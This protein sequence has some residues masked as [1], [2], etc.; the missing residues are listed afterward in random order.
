MPDFQQTIN[1]NQPLGY[2]G[3]LAFSG[4][5]RA[6][7]YNL[8]STPQVNAIGNA[9]TVVNGA[10]P[11]PAA[12]SAN[13]GT[14]KVGGTGVFA[15]ILVNPKEYASFGGVAGPLAATYNLPENAIGI[16]MTMGIILVNISNTTASVGDLVY[17]DQTTGA[18]TSVPEFASFTG[19]VATNTLTVSGY[20][21]GGPPIVVGSVISGTGV[22]PGTRVTALGS[23][24]GGNGTYTV[25]GPATVGSTA[26]RSTSPAP[27]GKTFVPRCRVY[28][29]DVAAAGLAAIELTN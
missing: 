8:V 23:G 3:E 6:L 28:A 9:F 24:T 20:V 25:D 19:V 27:T 13:A 14:A 10:N 7:P 21:A 29:Y 4:P 15:G 12:G 5:T 11:D 18:L 22:T 2:A 17:F 26:M 1:I 16:L